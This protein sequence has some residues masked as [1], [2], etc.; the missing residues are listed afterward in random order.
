MDPATSYRVVFLGIAEGVER[1]E[2]ATR[3]AA[4]LKAAPERIEWLLDSPGHV[5]KTGL[6]P[7]VA[8]RYQQAI[9]AAGASCRVEPEPL[10]DVAV[11]LPQ[12]APAS[13]ARGSTPPSEMPSAT[14]GKDFVKLLGAAVLA[15]VG[16]M[17]IRDF[18]GGSREVPEIIIHEPLRGIVDV[19]DCRWQYH[20]LHCTLANTGDSAINTYKLDFESNCYNDHG[21]KV[22]RRGFTAVIDPKGSAEVILC[23]YEKHQSGKAVLGI[24]GRAE[25]TDD[26]RKDATGAASAWVPPTSGLWQ[27]DNATRGR[28]WQLWTL[29]QDGT[30]RYE[31]EEGMIQGS[32]RYQWNGTTELQTQ[33]DDNPALRQSWT[34]LE[35]RGRDWLMSNGNFAVFCHG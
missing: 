1:E 8:T 3:L 6:P 11:S 33:D 30:Y 25:L 23:N 13:A 4:L 9:A 20:L 24:R 15:V 29:A 21:T 16:V 27:C 12:G 10:S 14:R 34:V 7:D 26:D 31:G 18:M 28:K 17:T 5:L 35:T 22:D 32:G 19:R 2:A